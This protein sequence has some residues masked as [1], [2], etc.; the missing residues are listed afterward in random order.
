MEIQKVK[1]LCKDFFEKNIFFGLPREYIKKNSSLRFF[2]YSAAKTLVSSHLSLALAFLIH[3]KQNSF[4]KTSRTD[5]S[6]SS[7]SYSNPGFHF[8]SHSLWKSV[9][10][11]RDRSHSQSP[12]VNP[13]QRTST[14]GSTPRTSKRPR[15]DAIK[16]ALFESSCHCAGTGRARSDNLP[17]RNTTT[18][19][20]RVMGQDFRSLAPVRG[21]VFYS[22][23]LT[24][25]YLIYRMTCQRNRISLDYRFLRADCHKFS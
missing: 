7:S 10:C 25:R 12:S 21:L 20:A 4:S 23:I 6:S 11:H 15:V 18:T 3:N 19:C 14:E 5:R 17:R 2:F 22:C 9:D 8:D 1:L 24:V 16:N 13:V